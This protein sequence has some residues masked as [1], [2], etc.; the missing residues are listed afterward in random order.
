MTLDDPALDDEDDYEAA[1][2]LL[3]ALRAA[4]SYVFIDEGTLFCSPPAR[5]VEWP[6]DAE[7]AIETHYYALRALVAATSETVH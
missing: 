6:G 7:E 3:A 5:H 2:R 1:A 4:G